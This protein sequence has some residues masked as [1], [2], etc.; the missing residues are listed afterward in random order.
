MRTAQEIHTAWCDYMVNK[1]TAPRRIVSAKTMQKMPTGIRLNR[2]TRNEIILALAKWER[3]E[4]H[5]ASIHILRPEKRRH[6]YTSGNGN[7]L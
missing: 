7:D 4:K 1:A 2:M 3:E 5:H 6:L